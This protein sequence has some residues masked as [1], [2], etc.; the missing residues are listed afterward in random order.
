MTEVIEIREDYYLINFQSLLDFVTYQY[1]D[2]LVDDESTFINHFRNASEPARRLYVRLICRKGPLFRSDTLKYPEILDITPAAR[3]LEKLGLMAINTD[4][5]VS[6]MVKLGTKAELLK[7]FSSVSDISSKLK[8]PDLV[9]RIVTEVSQSPTLPFDI[10]E[11]LFAEQ[12]KNLQFLFF[13]NL[14]QDLTEFVLQDLGLNKF[15][16]YSLE[17]N[18]RLFKTRSELNDALKLSQLGIL[19]YEA[20]FEKDSKALCYLQHELPDQ[21]A[22]P[23]LKRRFS[24]L[25]N[26]IAR[27]LER[28]EQFDEALRLFAQSNLPPATERMARIRHKLGEIEASKAICTTIVNNPASDMELEFAKRFIRK[29]KGDRASRKQ[30][31]FSEKHLSLSD[32][33]ERVELQVQKHFQNKGWETFYVENTLIC[34]LAGLLFW[35][36]LFADIPDAFFHPF[37]SAPA[38]LSTP[39]F[40]RKRQALFENRFRQLE[41]SNVTREALTIYEQKQ[42]IANRLVYWPRLSE[43]LITLACDL[44]PWTH[45]KAM[46][47]KLVFDFAH[48]RTGFPDL[49]LFKPESQ[50]YRWVE[51]KGPGD[52]LQENQKRWLAFFAE[53][54]MPAEVIYVDWLKRVREHPKH[55]NQG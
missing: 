10:Y 39:D 52:R 28:T 11:P 16:N 37:Q 35:D 29:L 25:V 30:P 44:I 48:N 14:H 17:K 51:V 22:S 32:N 6:E 23:I 19:A 46:L 54:D 43:K 20:E 45:L 42:G 4:T 8:R 18:S 36:I 50:E 13:G 15:E 49:I 47:E 33:S 21:P 5:D 7:W 34:G 31:R 12:V 55:V 24:R 26:R 9:E 41:A 3:E 53:R 27:A 1:E 38:D 40:Y 2:L